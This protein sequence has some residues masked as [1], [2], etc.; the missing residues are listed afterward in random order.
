MA[1]EITNTLGIDTSGFGNALSGAGSAIF[2]FV[3]FVA[4]AGVIF[5]FMWFISFKQNLI[6]KKKMNNGMKRNVRKCKIIVKKDGQSFLQVRNPN[7]MT[8]ILHPTPPLDCIETGERGKEYISAYE[9]ET[10]ELIYIKDSG[11]IPELPK[12]ILEIQDLFARAEAIRNW[13]KENNVID[14]YKPITANQR[15]FYLGQIRQANEK[16]KK[17]VM[18]LIRDLAPVMAIVV[19][20]AIM[21]IF[22]GKLYEPATKLGE[23][24]VE[25]DKLVLQLANKIDEIDNN[26]QRIVNEDK[27]QNTAPS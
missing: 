7:P 2:Y 21:L 11:K 13:K 12:E 25:H 27:Q 18:E 10:G 23:Q 20:F 1:N 17:T 6:I 19:M 26:V 8:K 22:G 4:I 15:T 16:T 24:V 14:A 5:Y 3:L 9:T